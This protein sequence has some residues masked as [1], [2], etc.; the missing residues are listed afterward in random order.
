MGNLAW[1]TLVALGLGQFDDVSGTAR[2]N[3]PRAKAT[4][5]ASKKTPKP[6]GKAIHKQ[7][8]TTLAGHVAE[9]LN[10][11]FTH[12][13]NALR[14]AKREH[15]AARRLDPDDPRIE[16]ALG[17]VQSRQMHH[18]A[19]LTQ[20]KLAVE[21]GKK[22]YWPAVQALIWSECCEKRYTDGLDRLMKFAEL[23]QDNDGDAAAR[24]DAANWIGQ[25]LE[26]LDET[27]AADR[28]RLALVHAEAKILAAL[29][30]ELKGALDH[31]R[32]IVREKW[33]LLSQQTNDVVEQRAQKVATA[34]RGTAKQ[35][36]AQVEDIGK[37][38][39]A[40]KRTREQWD[41]WIEQQMDP[42][43]DQLGHLERDYLY[44]NRRLGSLT[45]SIAVTARELAQLE[46]QDVYGRNSLWANPAH[47]TGGNAATFTPLQLAIQNLRTTIFGYQ[48]DYNA[49]AARMSSTVQQANA[50]VQRRSLAG[51]QYQTATGQL[52]T[53]NNQLARWATRLEEKKKKLEHQ[54]PAKEL[55]ENLER[56]L[57]WFR[58]Y[59]G[60]DLEA[61]K[62]RI[63][64]SYGI[65][66]PE[67]EAVPPPIPAKEPKIL[68]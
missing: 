53:K 33:R 56:K 23:V 19:A 47:P 9:M 6:A 25:V 11:G 54:V 62:L 3:A 45:Q 59:V 31:G 61:E 1:L 20:F 58:T 41:Q 57:T 22:P 34:N 5:K 29:D 13:P 60:L 12:G 30:G 37:E 52:L 36:D 49:T 40:T 65:P 7:F 42:I 44:L 21:K 46:A 51:Q 18:Q 67:S 17:L 50:L 10:E 28:D 27:L 39:Q 66:P 32:T 4:V 15:V 63:F 64:E 43:D 8:P 14:T 48:L 16:Y 38:R 55:Q 24:D 68:D 35:I 2:P 26:G